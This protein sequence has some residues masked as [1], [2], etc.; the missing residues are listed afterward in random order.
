[1]IAIYDCAVNGFLVAVK[2]HCASTEQFKAV[3]ASYMSEECSHYESLLQKMPTVISI[4]EYRPEDIIADIKNTMDEAVS[5]I[6]LEETLQ[7]FN[8]MQKDIVVLLM[9]GYSKQDIAD[10][11]HISFSALIDQIYLIQRKT[12]SSPLMTAA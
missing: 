10:M 2:K 12:L 8:S 11:L 9:S 4:S 3:S 6:A 5:A 7:S 1:M